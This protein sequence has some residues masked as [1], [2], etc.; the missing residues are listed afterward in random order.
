[1]FLQVSVYRYVQ[2]HVLSGVGIS[3]AR[4]LLG[5]GVGTH[6]LLRHEIS[7]GGEWVPTHPPSRDIGYNGIRLASR[8]Y[9]SYRNAF[10]LTELLQT[11]WKYCKNVSTFQEKFLL[12]YL[13]WRWEMV[14][15][16]E[17]CYFT[18]D[19]TCT[20]RP[21]DTDM[22]CT[23]KDKKEQENATKTSAKCL[24]AF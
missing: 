6:P 13:R 11:S 24:I 7:G 21:T 19:P 18:E 22:F 9:A 5:V 17:F 14:I 23:S 16:D 1:M 3:G 20:K 10:L 8:Q 4:S 2:S 15:S 12:R